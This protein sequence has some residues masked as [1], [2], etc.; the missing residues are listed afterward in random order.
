MNKT[1]RTLIISS[2][3]MALAFVVAVVGVSA[4]WFG[5]MKSAREG[6]FIIESDTLQDVASIDINSVKG[7]SGE[8]IY[9]AVAERG[10]FLKNGAIPPVGAALR[11]ETLPAG[12]T[13]APVAATMYLPIQFIGTPDSGYEKE[14]RKS[15]ALSLVSANLSDDESETP[16]DYIDEFDVI[17]CLVEAQLNEEGKFESEKGVLTTT[18]DYEP[19]TGGNIFYCLQN[20]DLYLLVQPGITYYVKVQLYFNKIDEEC[21]LDLLDTVIKFNFKLNALDD[22]R[23]IREGQYKTDGGEAND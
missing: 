18:Q 20:Y 11:A 17:M 22:G 12:V 8:S 6:G 9:P 15:L 23:F 10:Y 3:I 2:C 14:N 7:M 21:N 5:D 4:A 16:F 13:E 19:L 1:K